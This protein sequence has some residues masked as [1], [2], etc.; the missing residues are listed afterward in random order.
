M[1]LLLIAMLMILAVA[2]VVVAYVAYPHR[3]EELP[4]APRLGEALRRGVESMP[5]LETTQTRR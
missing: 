3:G 4:G 2:G 1:L 5:T